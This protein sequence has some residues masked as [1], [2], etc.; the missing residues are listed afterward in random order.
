MSIQ[1]DN[2]SGGY[3]QPDQSSNASMHKRDLRVEEEIKPLDDVDSKG[4]VAADGEVHLRK[5]LP[6]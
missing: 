5:S 6:E 1:N 3:M 4:A 2:A